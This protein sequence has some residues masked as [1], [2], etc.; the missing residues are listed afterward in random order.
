M[1]GA[2]AERHTL[3]DI[4]AQRDKALQDVRD[5]G[6]EIKLRMRRLLEQPRAE[7][8]LGLLI[9]NVDKIIAV[10]DGVLLGMSI[11]RKVRRF[12]TR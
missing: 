4:L 2:R 11:V 1:Y 7:G 3:E 10:C 6:A 8:K 5:S 9:G 12:V